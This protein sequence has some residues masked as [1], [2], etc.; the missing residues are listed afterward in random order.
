[1]IILV[2]VWAL[3][4]GLSPGLALIAAAIALLAVDARDPRI[5][6]SAFGP[7]AARDDD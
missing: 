5:L 3:V 7:P 6:D 1:V 4:L 2:I